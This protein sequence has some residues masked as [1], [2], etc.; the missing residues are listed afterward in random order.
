MAAMLSVIIPTYNR[1]HSLIRCLRALPGNVEV[2]VVDDGSTDGTAD[3]I[4][5]LNQPNL[6]YLRQPNA[7]PA[8]ARN[9]GI[10][11]ASGDYLAFTDDDCVP[12]P[13]WPWPLVEMLQKSSDDVAGVGGK[14]VA[15]RNGL[16]SRYY[17]FHHILE[18]PESCSYLVTANCVYRAEVIHSS[19]GFNTQIRR[20]GGEDPG[21]SLDVRTMGYRLIYLDEAVVAH[22][23]R[24]SPVDFIRTFY[25]YGRGC[26]AS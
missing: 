18:P 19:R 4:H 9:A 5:E 22:D 14:V 23:F 24:Q 15:L 1:K 11:R 20:A 16:I 10:S 8:S 17:A 13:R 21:L 3:F 12:M 6:I 2:I 7:G 25:R 26:N